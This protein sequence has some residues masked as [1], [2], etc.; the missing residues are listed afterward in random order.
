MGSGRFTRRLF[1]ERSEVQPE[2]LGWG[3][4]H[5]RPRVAEPAAV[6]AFEQIE[7]R[8][9]RVYIFHKP[10]YCLLTKFRMRLSCCRIEMG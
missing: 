10:Q 2:V 3:V 5:E 7:E 9:S 4:C 8:P 6:T 1:R